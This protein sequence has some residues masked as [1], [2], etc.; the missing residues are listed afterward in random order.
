MMDADSHFGTSTEVST[1]YMYNLVSLC[2]SLLQQQK[3]LIQFDKIDGITLL[4]AF[5]GN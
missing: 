2:G 5:I 4:A 3:Q 1:S